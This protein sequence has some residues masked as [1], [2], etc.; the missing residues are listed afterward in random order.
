MLAALVTGAL[1]VPILASAFRSDLRVLQFPAA[2]R[3]TP[4]AFLLAML[5]HL[6]LSSGFEHALYLLAAPWMS[7][8][9]AA[10]MQALQAASV[11]GV[12]V[13][14]GVGGVGTGVGMG[15]ADGWLGV[16]AVAVPVPVP[17]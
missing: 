13:G 1:P 3:A 2:P 6:L 5:A 9:D 11:L 12:G 7:P 15:V 8:L 16:V 17:E 10:A 4:T 14:V